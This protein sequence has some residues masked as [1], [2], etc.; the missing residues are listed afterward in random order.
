MRDVTLTVSGMH[1]AAC[2]L[3]ID[4]TLLDVEGVLSAVT[5]VK[6]GVCEVT[7]EES[8]PLAALVAAVAEAGYEATLA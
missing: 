5:S 1:C 3:L 6:N 4:D 2:G 8:V 7:V